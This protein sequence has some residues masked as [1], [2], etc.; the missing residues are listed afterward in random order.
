MR[1][2]L[3]DK[4]LFCLANK[5]KAREWKSDN[6]RKERNITQFPS[7]FASSKNT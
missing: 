4:L 7:R 6:L 5:L 3:E 2:L 1:L